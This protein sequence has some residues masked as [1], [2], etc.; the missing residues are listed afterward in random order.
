MVIPIANALS[1]FEC[2]D[3]EFGP[4]VSAAQRFAGLFKA[5]VLLFWLPGWWMHSRI[6]FDVLTYL[7]KK[8]KETLV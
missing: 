3:T 1:A 5:D 7:E 2:D 6:C 8:R 4:R